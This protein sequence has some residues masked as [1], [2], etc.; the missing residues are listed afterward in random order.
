MRFL[1][2]YGRTFTLLLFLFPLLGVS[3]TYLYLQYQETKEE[4]VEIVQDSMVA[5]KYELLDIYIEYLRTEFGDDFVSVLRKDE[6]ARVQAE[7]SLSLM[8]NSEV[9]FLYVLYIDEKKRFRYLIDT[10]QDLKEKGEFKQRF[11]PQKYIWAKAL[12]EKKPK[13]TAQKEIDKLWISMAYPILKDNKTVALLGIDFSHMEYVKVKKTLTP[14]ENIYLYSAIFIVVMLISAFVQLI[15]YYQHRKKSFIDPLTGMFNRQYLY[16]L[17]RKYS[18][19]DFQ[20]LIMDLDHFKQVNDIYGHD[21][22]DEVLRTVSARIRSV[23]RKKDILIRYGG[24]EFLLLISE[25]E[26]DI[27]MGLAQRVR[28]AVKANPI[29]L[30]SSQLNVTISMGL[31]PLPEYSKDFEQAIK[32]ADL[33]LYKAKQLGRDRVEIYDDN[34]LV[35]EESLQRMCDVRDALDKEK[36][37]CVY[38]AIFKTSTLEVQRYE[39]LIRMLDNN[40]KV[41]SPSKFLP[42]IRYTQVYTNLTKKIF[43]FAFDTLSNNDIKISINLDLQDLFNDELLTALIDIFSKDLS[44][45]KRLGIEILE[46]EENIDFSLVAQRLSKIKELGIE[47]AIDNFGSGHANYRY[48]LNMDINTLKIDSSLIS[49]IDTNKN[50]Y[51]IVKS[52]HTLA[53][54]MGIKTVAEHIETEETLECVKALGIDYVQ[55]YFLEKPSAKF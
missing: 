49:N 15:I 50:A 14:L 52:I 4:I 29:D 10:T 19:G 48:L 34:E 13:V 2:H 32:I 45:A 42:S 7:T 27:S 23:I 30:E 31:N 46:S 44:L 16:E 21:A 33:G 35:D 9:Q 53:K 39:L 36:V 40:D 41:I 12:E 51:K 6:K 18:V 22:G 37:F 25:K 24:E 5:K 11:F 3:A 1:V 28:E 8:K 26:L 47:I 43:E 20:L 38:Q 55:G 17:L 54:E